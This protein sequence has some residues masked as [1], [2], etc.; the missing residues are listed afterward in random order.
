[1]GVGFTNISCT[2]FPEF[3]AAPEKR[4]SL[5]SSEWTKGRIIQPFAGEDDLVRNIKVRANVGAYVCPVTKVF[6]I[7]PVFLVKVT[8]SRLNSKLAFTTAGRNVAWD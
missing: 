8:T 5:L 1:M 3:R 6:V 4:D 7:C 2:S